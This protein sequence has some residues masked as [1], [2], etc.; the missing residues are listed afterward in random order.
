M[1]L[2][3]KIDTIELGSEALGFSAGE[4]LRQQIIERR[5]DVLQKRLKGAYLKGDSL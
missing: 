3:K 2:D 5:S 4:W 1:L